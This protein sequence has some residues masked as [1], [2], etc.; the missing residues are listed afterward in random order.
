[1]RRYYY[2]T[3]TSYLELI[4]SYKTLLE[5]KREEIDD[6]IRKFDKG[7][8]QLSKAQKTVNEL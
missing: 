6:V 1:M 5:K 8:K 3:P 4:T 7:L 2:V